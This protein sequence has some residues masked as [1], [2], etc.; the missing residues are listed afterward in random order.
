MLPR[1]TQI[2]T[3]PSYRQDEHSNQASSRVLNVASPVVKR[4]LIFDYDDLA[5]GLS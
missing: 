4:F 5:F 2:Q 1:L 3:K